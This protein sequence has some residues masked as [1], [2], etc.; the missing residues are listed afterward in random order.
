MSKSKKSKPSGAKTSREKDPVQFRLLL[1]RLAGDARL[2]RYQRTILP[3]VLRAKIDCTPALTRQTDCLITA[4]AS[5]AQ[6]LLS[7][8][9]FN[10]LTA[11]EKSDIVKIIV[12]LTLLVADRKPELVSA[13][14]KSTVE[15]LLGQTLEEYFRE[16][17]ESFDLD[18]QS[19]GGI[20]PQLTEEFKRQ[21][22]NARSPRDLERI[23]AETR[24]RLQPKCVGDLE[25]FAKTAEHD[26]HLIKT[27]KDAL[28]L[29][30]KFTNQAG[31]SESTKSNILRL[32]HLT[33][34][35]GS[36]T[37]THGLDIV[38][39]LDD[40]NLDPN[41]GSFDKLI[42][43]LNDN[44]RRVLAAG[45]SA[46]TKMTNFENELIL[47]HPD[48]QP[49]ADLGED[50]THL[51]DFQPLTRLQVMIDKE[52]FF[53]QVIYDINVNRSVKKL[54]LFLSDYLRDLG[55]PD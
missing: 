27:V 7:A 34:N 48:A 38:G 47:S 53:N 42:D 54:R 15:I 22:N 28:D 40:L 16:G 1:H 2:A 31:Q 12:H 46:Q 44:E 37:K 51:I 4:S 13:S 36:E 5:M 25:Y 52:I 14:L 49:I 55:T 45:L 41:Y 35:V 32:S 39:R 11:Q 33:T 3:T 26:H 18:D 17:L 43:R 30:D 10:S 23:G 21:V 19:D 29:I 24:R 6:A 20:N 8:L 9:E 50:V